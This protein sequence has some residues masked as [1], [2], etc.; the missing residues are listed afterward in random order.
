MPIRNPKMPTDRLDEILS[1]PAEARPA[2]LEGRWLESA[3][4]RCW[5]AAEPSSVL[6]GCADALRELPAWLERQSKK[7]PAGAAIGF[8]SYELAR[9]LE[10]LP[11]VTHRSLPDVSFAYYPRI[12]CFQAA[13]AR[14]SRTRGNVRI[15]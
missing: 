10:P 14:V 5:A 4:D 15:D 7:Y 11:L 9:H 1:Q 13:A 2:L 3:P 12:E 8:L 6:E